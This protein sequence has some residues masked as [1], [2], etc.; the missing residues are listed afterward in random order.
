MCQQYLVVHIV[1]CAFFWV[2]LGHLLELFV[3]FECCVWLDLCVCQCLNFGPLC[4][5]G[6]SNVH[7]EIYNIISCA[8]VMILQIQLFELKYIVLFVHMTHYLIIVHFFAIVLHLPMIIMYHNISARD[9][10]IDPCALHKHIT[11]A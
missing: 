7:C 6:W 4:L 5:K 3:L 1:R 10:P 2:L 11:Y 8:F 9:D